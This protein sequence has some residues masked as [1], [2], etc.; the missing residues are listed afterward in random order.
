MK[1]IVPNYTHCKSLQRIKL[2]KLTV[3]EDYNTI[4]NGLTKRGAKCK[5]NRGRPLF[6]VSKQSDSKKVF[7]LEMPLFCATMK[8]YSN[9]LL[10]RATFRCFLGS[11]WCNSPFA[12]Y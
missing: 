12:P 6:S 7:I 11:G 5:K 8:K 4:N 2:K 9:I 10:R 3:K 1:T